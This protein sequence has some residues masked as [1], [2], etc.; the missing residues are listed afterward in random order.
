MID[1]RTI[2]ETKTAIFGLQT[3]LNTKNTIL[4]PV[5]SR[6]QD[7]GLETTS[8]H[9]LITYVEIC[10]KVLSVK[11]MLAEQLRYATQLVSNLRA[12]VTCN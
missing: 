10:L 5:E 2:S 9:M 11:P 8:D 12:Q 1:W 4:R 3:G 7:D 6:D